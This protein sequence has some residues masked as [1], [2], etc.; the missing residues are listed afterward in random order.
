MNRL[1][2]NTLVQLGCNDKHVR[3]YE[4][5]LKLGDAPLGDILKVARLQ[6]STAYL[7]ASE[8]IEKGLIKEDHKQYKKTFTAVSPDVLLQKLEAKHRR[9][10]RDAI[11]LKEALP[12]LAALQGGT[13]R[14][15]VRT[16]Q[17][18]FG[19]LAMRQE[20]LKQQQE[21]LLWT[22]QA[23]ERQIFNQDSHDHF[24]SERID[25]QIPIRVLAVDNPEG[26]E[27][28]NTDATMLRHTK[29]LPSDV[30]F[31]SETYI[32]GDTVAV[33]DVSS[34][35]FGVVTKNS[36]IADSQ[37]ALFNLTWDSL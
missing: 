6:R 5:N 32:Y 33:I 37:R 36:Q 10:G 18:S 29:I 1:I 17:G 24:V 22:N 35:T 13:S 12:E 19:L 23:A 26:R 3:F 4:A 31:T 11:A 21:V 14:P 8:L 20:I 15:Q 7:L 30:S 16:Y 27:L 34:E 9:I 28:V 25:K 2:K